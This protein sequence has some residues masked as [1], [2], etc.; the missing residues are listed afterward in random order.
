MLGIGA[1]PDEDTAGMAD[2]DGIEVFAAGAGS[3][4]LIDATP[5]VKAVG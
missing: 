1:H 3:A 2:S 4:G 5:C